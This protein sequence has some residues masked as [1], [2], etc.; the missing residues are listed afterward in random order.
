MIR[1]NLR[2]IQKMSSGSNLKKEHE[3]IIINGVST[4]SRNINI[5][6]LF[7][8]LT[9]EN[10]NGHKF[11]RDAIKKGAVAALWSRREPIPNIDFPFILVD[12]TLIALQELAKAYRNQLRTKVI[13]IT[14]SNGKTSTKDILA[15]LLKTRYKT[16]KTFGNFNN[17]IGVPLT[18]LGM[19]ED[20]EMAVIEMGMSNLGEIELLTSIAAP[21]VGVITNIGEAHLEDLKTKEN[22]IKAKLEILKGLNPNGLFLYFGDDSMLKEKV[23]SIPMNYEV[24]TFGI[25]SSNT[26]Q[27]QVGF[28]NEKGVSFFLKNP[29]SPTF[30]LPMLG[31]HQI[32][33]ATAAIAIARY[34]NISFKNIQKGFLKVEK[35]GMRNE[36][37]HG[38]DFTILNDSYKSN[39]TSVLAALET[40]YSMEGYNQKIVVL[41]DMQ[42]LGKYETKMHE[43]IGQKINSNKVDFLFTI[44]PIS[45]HIGKTAIMSFGKDRVTSC[46]DKV[47][48]VAEL[49]KV[50][51]PNALILVKASRALQL[52]EIVDKLKEE[53]FLLHENMVNRK[54]EIN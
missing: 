49:K 22:I 1:R 5:G 54:L 31:E 8:P 18:I 9:G 27:F 39:P 41:G 2:E 50:I 28:V 45:H 19:D 17:H 36:L 20:T 23:K 33:N 15:S 24:M 14:G 40:V 6:Q 3:E 38:K 21:D 35:T 52:E 43:E 51:K 47:Q 42:G 11:I 44:G 37:V 7:V 13:G 16:H 34:F 4:D 25:K 32:Y 30:F 53:T 26:Y 46:A 10:F 12:D 29:I 48:L